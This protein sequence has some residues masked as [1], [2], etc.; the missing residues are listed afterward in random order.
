MSRASPCPPGKSTGKACV[1]TTRSSQEHVLYLP[2]ARRSSLCGPEANGRESGRFGSKIGSH[3]LVSAL[4]FRHRGVRLP[5]GVRGGPMPTTATRL[6]HD[7]LGD[8]AVP[9]DVYYGVQ[10]ARALENFNI[11][12]VRLALYPNLIKASAWS[13][14]RRRAPTRVQ[15]IQ[16][17]D[18]DGHRG[19]LPGTDRRQAAR[20]VPARRLSRRR[21]H[22]DEHERQRGDRQSRARV[23]GPSEGRVHALRSARSRQ[24]LAIDERR[25]SVGASRR[26]GARQRRARGGGERADCRVP[27]EGQGVSRRAEDGTHAAPGRGP[28]D[29]RPGIRSL[30]GHSRGRSAGLERDPARAVRDR[31]WAPPRSAR[32]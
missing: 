20:P 31:T 6:E 27:R 32:A 30:C 4:H 26:H 24:R 9:I 3:R 19:G 21:G 28:D 22:L 1:S 7:L 2:P 8:K 16:Q 11:S 10:T 18:P 29:A 23:D 14:W 12:G 25:V 15:A 13:R 5:A 17:G